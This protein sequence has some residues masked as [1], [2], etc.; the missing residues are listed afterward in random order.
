MGI[1]LVHTRRN[2]KGYY[3]AGL[4]ISNGHSTAAVVASS[5]VVG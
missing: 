1:L 3:L 5:S 2:E 4:V